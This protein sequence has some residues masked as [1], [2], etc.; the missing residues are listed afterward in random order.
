MKTRRRGRASPAA[1]DGGR[2]NEEADSPLEQVVGG[3]VIGLILLTAFGLLAA[4]YDW[5]WVVFPVGFAGLLP[6]AVGLVRWYERRNRRERP[7]EGRRAAERDRALATLRDR[8]A[9]GEIDDEEFERRL[10]RVL[11]TETLAD[12]ATERD[13]RGR[14]APGRVGPDTGDSDRVESETGASDGVESERDASGEGESES[15]VE[16]G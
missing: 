8:Y 5:F 11:S 2:E 4:G 3:V 10:D 1:T 13:R 12:A 7:R 14:G 9:R 16:R 6:A 15:D